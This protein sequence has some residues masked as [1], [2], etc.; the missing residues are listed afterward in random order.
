MNHNDNTYECSEHNRCPGPHAPHLGGYSVCDCP[1]CHAK[2][3]FNCTPA[4][5]A[6]LRENTD[7]V[8]NLALGRLRGLLQRAEDD[9]DA[10]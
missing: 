1:S 9:G 10:A 7:P 6:V 2:G 5:G 3:R 8:P 4:P